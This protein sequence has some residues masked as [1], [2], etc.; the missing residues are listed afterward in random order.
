MISRMILVLGTLVLPFL[1]RADES[2]DLVRYYA[3]FDHEKVERDLRGFLNAKSVA[4]KI[5]FVREPGRVALLMKAY[6][7]KDAYQPE[8]FESFKRGPFNFRDRFVF[9]S[10][11]TGDFLTRPVTLKRSLKDGK[12]HYLIDWESWVG[13]SEK[14]PEV[15]E[16]SSW[17]LFPKDDPTA[18]DQAEPAQK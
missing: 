14:T 4:E 15:I 8:G 2:E 17:I 18:D 12:E 6:Y 10:V 1:A 11:E 13:Y 9:C 16:A 5:K 7:A 3:S